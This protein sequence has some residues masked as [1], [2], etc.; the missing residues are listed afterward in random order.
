M[1]FIVTSMSYLSSE[2]S[3]CSFSITLPV[4]NSSILR[5]K[6]CFNSSPCFFFSI[7][8]MSVLLAVDRLLVFSFKL[9]VPISIS[10]R[11]WFKLTLEMFFIPTVFLTLLIVFLS[12]DNVSLPIIIHVLYHLLTKNATIRPNTRKKISTTVI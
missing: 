2:A 7:S 12:M 11:F 3:S 4:F 5:F 6:N 9:H 1:S 10:K 8:F